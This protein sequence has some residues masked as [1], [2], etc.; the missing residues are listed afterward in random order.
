MET[1]AESPPTRKAWILAGS[2]A[3]VV[4]LIFESVTPLVAAPLREISS[5]LAQGFLQAI[6]FPVSRAGTILSTPRATFDV[7]PACSGSTTLQVLLFLS[8][9]WCGVHPRLNPGRRVA[10]ILLAFPLAILANAL[11]VSALVAMGHAAGGEPDGVV[12]SLTGVAAFALAMLGC[13]A[14]TQRLAS[15][16]NVPGVRDRTLTWILGGLLALLSLPFLAWCLENWG[17]GSTDRYGQ[18]FLAA[19]VAVAVWKWKRSPTDRPREGW[20]TV[21]LGISFL[22]MAV[23]TLVDVNILRG[24]SLLLA[25]LSLCLAHKGMRFAA[26]MIPVALL[27]YLGFPS[28]SYQLGALTSWR[29]TG[30]GSLLVL[31]SLAALILLASLMAPFFRSAGETSAAGGRRFLPLQILMA[32]LLAA[33]QTY[34]YGFAGSN[35]QESRLEMSYLQGPWVGADLEPPRS[36][37]DYFGKD[38]IWYRRFLREGAGVDVLVTSTGGDRHR[39]HPPAYCVS[40]DG[41]ETVETDVSER[42]LGDGARVPM[43]VLRLRKGS[44]ELTFCYWFT[45]GTESFAGF[46]GMVLH[47]TLRRLGGR[48]ADWFVF[49]VM[50]PSGGAALDAFLAEFRPRLMPRGR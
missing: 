17:G 46:S 30:L 24:L 32:A 44:E 2:V 28:V 48:R 18:F 35:L 9:V 1:P 21:G 22:G 36:E 37:S 23:S 47:D 5:I 8:I 14:I 50:T 16:S 39:A 34:C 12:H 3:A 20:G 27:A 19:A 29:F 26:S 49:R 11:R 13:F 40:G 43:T 45:N 42:R 6:G 31:K 7:V 15:S 25:F 4:F 33:F 38:R 41:W 10:A